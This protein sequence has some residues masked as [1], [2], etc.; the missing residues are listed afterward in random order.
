MKYCPLG[1]P[2]LNSPQLL[3]KFT[4]LIE[5]DGPNTNLRL[6]NGFII[7]PTKN[8]NTLKREANGETGGDSE[9]LSD[10]KYTIIPCTVENMAFRGSTLRNTAVVYGIVIYTGKETRVG[11]NAKKS[12]KKFS[13]VER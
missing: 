2:N 9:S 6:F 5:C 13:T 1:L 3:S 8:L 10:S 12:R 11:M 4:G 7:V